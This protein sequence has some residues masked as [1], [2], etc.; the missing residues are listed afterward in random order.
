MGIFDI[1]RK[2]TED[3]VESTTTIR[4]ASDARSDNSPDNSTPA[5]AVSG[6]FRFVIDDV[7]SITGRGTVVTGKVESGQVSVGEAVQLRKADGEC[8]SVTVNGIE[9]F[10]QMLQTASEGMNVGILI[11]DVTKSDVSRGD[12]LER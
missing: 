6:S 12:V 4:Y 10:R 7:F 11:S 1:L 8:K 5:M 9:V 3:N 2:I